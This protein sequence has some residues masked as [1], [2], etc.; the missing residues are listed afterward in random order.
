MAGSE[1]SGYAFSSDHLFENAYYIL[2]PADE[3]GFD[4]IGNCME[5]IGSI[6]ALPMILTWE[7]HDYITAAISHLPH[8]VASALVNLIQKLDSPSEHMKTIAAGGFKD[9]TRIASSSPAMWQEICMENP[10]N[11]S[12][13]LDEFIRLIV[14]EKYLIDQRSGEDIYNMFAC[15][16]AYRDSFNDL[17]CGPIKKEYTIYCDILDETGAIATI[18]TILSMNRISIKNIGII[19]N[20]EFDD[21]VLKIDFYEEED[22][23]KAAEQLRKR[24]YILYER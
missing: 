24:N 20:R 17:S 3:A 14:Q 15:S 7:E 6:G 21:G 9:I 22:Q 4:K 18:A 1:K 5:L 13:V 11:I 23:K 16:S 8:L 19:N 12:G 2:T 10:E